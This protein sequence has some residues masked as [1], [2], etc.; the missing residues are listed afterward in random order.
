M[1]M[2]QKKI[3]YQ[4]WQQPA[5][6]RLI[7]RQVAMTVATSSV[8][9][10]QDTTGSR[11]R[12]EIQELLPA[13]IQLLASSENVRLL[14]QTMNEQARVFHACGVFSWTM[15]RE[16]T[17]QQ[18]SEQRESFLGRVKEMA[19]RTEGSIADLEKDLFVAT[20]GIDKKPC[21]YVSIS[22]PCGG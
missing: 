10:F 5:E 4:L 8:V 3:E 19:Q 16:V 1:Y 17:M 6:G 13:D 22:P 7:G 21:P 14:D 12:I 9:V 15:N 18:M 20:G 11:W 2:S